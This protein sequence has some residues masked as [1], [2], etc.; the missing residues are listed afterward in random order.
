MRNLFKDWDP[1]IGKLLSHCETVQKWKLCIRHELPEWSHPSGTFTLLGDAVHAT[2][3]YLASGAGISLEDGAVLGECLSR[4]NSK[5]DLKTALAVYE[6]CR[7]PRTSRIVQRGNVQQHL[8]HLHDGPEQ[9][10]RDRLMRLTPTLPGDPLVWRDPEL[11]PW[12]LGYNHIA[13]V[14]AHWPQSGPKA[15]PGS[16]M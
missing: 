16:K 1:R 3:P 15:G 7:R 14:D 5:S 13:D 2:L 4:I 6:A 12:L 8:Y 9:R 11:Q 10:E